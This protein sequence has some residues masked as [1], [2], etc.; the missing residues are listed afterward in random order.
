MV[1]DLGKIFAFIV[2][3][4]PGFRY[5]HD[6]HLSLSSWGPKIKQTGRL[7]GLVVLVVQR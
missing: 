3:V 7:A 1:G 6:G 4:F 2:V 5:S